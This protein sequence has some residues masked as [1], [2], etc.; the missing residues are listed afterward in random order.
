MEPHK[1][2]T[3]VHNKTSPGARKLLSRIALSVATSRVAQQRRISL[4][5][6][7]VIS[8]FCPQLP[9][10]DCEPQSH[11]NSI[12]RQTATDRRTGAGAFGEAGGDGVQLV[13]LTTAMK[14]RTTMRMT[15]SEEE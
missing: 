10:T 5:R 8:T 14:K 7:N 6:G 4:C 3:G 15:V 13:T 2:F 9:A 11:I 12:S 1:Q